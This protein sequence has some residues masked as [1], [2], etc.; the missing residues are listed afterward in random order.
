MRRLSHN[1]AHRK[2]RT[3]YTAGKLYTCTMLIMGG[4]KGKLIPYCILPEDN[5]NVIGGI[6]YFA[7][8]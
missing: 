3:I 5:V 2:R 8:L 4:A 7:I 1:T 6:D